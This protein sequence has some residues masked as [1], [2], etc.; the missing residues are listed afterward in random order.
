MHLGHIVVNDYAKKCKILAY[1]VCFFA[2]KQ[3]QVIFWAQVILWAQD[4]YNNLKLAHF[5]SNSL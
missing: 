3:K 1:K 2:V 5:S 4:E